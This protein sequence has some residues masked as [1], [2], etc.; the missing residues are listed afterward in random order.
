ML[1]QQ[2]SS[3]SRPVEQ[4]IE[5]V[6]VDRQQMRVEMR[7]QRDLIAQLNGLNCTFIRR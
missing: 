4:P 2:K 5:K 7:V 3:N 1:E 6:V